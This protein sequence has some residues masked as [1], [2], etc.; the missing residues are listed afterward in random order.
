MFTTRKSTRYF[1]CGVRS[2]A[3]TMPGP[4]FRGRRSFVTRPCRNSSA[5]APATP[6]TV[7]SS[8]RSPVIP[9]SLHRINIGAAAAGHNRAALTFPG[10]HPRQGRHLA[11]EPHV[12]CERSPLPC[13][14][15]SVDHA[16]PRASGHAPRGAQHLCRGIA[17]DDRLA[18]ARPQGGG[19]HHGPCRA[20][21]RKR[22]CGVGSGE[23][24]PVL[25]R[26]QGAGSGDRAFRDRLVGIGA[27]HGHR[28]RA[29]RLRSQP[30]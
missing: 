23:C 14:S 2:A 19:G 16:R 29:D 25:A 24:Q 15:R 17:R 3:H 20:L 6:I 4:F 8:A 26:R 30:A 18:L 1:P 27:R 22:P 28:C 21:H 7:L 10:A 11:G 12:P 13:D 9:L 5:S